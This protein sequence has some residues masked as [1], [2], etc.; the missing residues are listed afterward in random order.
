MFKGY[1][2]FFFILVCAAII[3]AAVSCETGDRQ[4]DDISD[5]S[6][7]AS[8]SEDDNVIETDDQNTDGEEAPQKAVSPGFDIDVFDKTEPLQTIEF[9]L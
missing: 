8:F 2:T 3:F 6:G 4:T 5:Y 7:D 9:K 1:K